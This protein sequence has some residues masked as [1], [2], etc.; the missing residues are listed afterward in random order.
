V[1]SVCVQGNSHGPGYVSR[2]TIR[3]EIVRASCFLPLHRTLFVVTILSE[4]NHGE[5][6]VVENLDGIVAIVF[7]S[8]FT[9]VD[10]EVRS[11]SVHV[12]T[13]NDVRPIKT[14]L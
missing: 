3:S 9:R 1:C 7:S 8:T 6:N 11:G 5:I 13:P 12:R 10:D 4:G 2:N 14:G